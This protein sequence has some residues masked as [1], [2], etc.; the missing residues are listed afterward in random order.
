MTPDESEAR[1]LLWVPACEPIPD[2]GRA[3]D[4]YHHDHD[5]ELGMYWYDPHPAKAFLER[6]LRTHRN[7]EYWLETGRLVR[8]Y[9]EA[10][11]GDAY[12]DALRQALITWMQASPA[13]RE[14]YELGD[15]MVRGELI[16]S[17]LKFLR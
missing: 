15:D 3:A 16:D 10:R 12:S 17:Y 2:D 6:P 1:Q 5:E 9:L 7:M 14:Q 4:G 11:A 13:R 8:E